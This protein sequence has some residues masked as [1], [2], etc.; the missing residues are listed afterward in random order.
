MDHLS[1][2]HQSTREIGNFPMRTALPSYIKALATTLLLQDEYGVN[3]GEEIYI[4]HH[5]DEMIKLCC[6]FHRRLDVNNF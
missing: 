5:D 3:L 2:E 1:A 4:W 6:R